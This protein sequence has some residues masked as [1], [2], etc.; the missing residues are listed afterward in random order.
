MLVLFICACSDYSDDAIEYIDVNG[1]RVVKIYPEKIK[2]E[3]KVKFSD[4]FED[5]RLIELESTP[6]SLIRYIGRTYVGEKY[7]IVSEPFEGILMFS[8]DGKFLRRIA[9]VGKGPGEVEDPNRNIFVDENNDRLYVTDNNLHPKKV[10]CYELLTGGHSY[11]PLVFTG[12]EMGIRDV[13]VMHDSLMY[14][15]KMTMMGVPSNQPVYC[16]T[17]SGRLV[18]EMDKTHPLGLNSATIDLSE[19]DLYFNY[20]FAGDTL[21]RLDG[22]ELTPIILLSSERPRSYL[23]EEPG[24]ISMALQH[25]TGD[26][27]RGGFSVLEEFYT[28]ENSN[29]QMPRYS[30]FWFLLDTKRGKV[31]R[32][33]YL[34]NDFL[35]L[36][37]KTNF[38]I[39]HNGVGVTRLE[40]IDLIHKAD[41]VSRI[42]GISGELKNRLE[43]ILE[44]VDE[45][46]NPYLLIGRLKKF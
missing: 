1:A 32:F 38:Q 14:C 35:G 43:N 24:S 19:G 29:R 7:I 12:G 4:W 41:S 16:Q 42:P 34:E 10:G 18:W 30:T 33:D 25:L 39:G 44:T 27:F 5:I 36:E 31:E 9:E 28:R 17:T 3:A 23:Q 21:Y 37:E 40:A 26:T 8:A 46:D 22:Q 6:E 13:I 45:N 15:T 11:I 20:L 2:N